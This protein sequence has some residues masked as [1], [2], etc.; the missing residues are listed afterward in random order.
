MNV[1]QSNVSRAALADAPSSPDE[2][3]L[4]TPNSA[5]D[6]AR[7]QAGT[8]APIQDGD[9]PDIPAAYTYLGQFTD[10][11]VTFAPRLALQR[12]ERLRCPD[13]LPDPF[14]LGHLPR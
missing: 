1:D 2:V 4:Q 11:H 13:G 10:H 5:K 12:T 14:A 6:W 8:G 9:N 7:R 3:L